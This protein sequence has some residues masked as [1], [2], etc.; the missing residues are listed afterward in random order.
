MVG[1]G[2]VRYGLV[3]YR[4]ESCWYDILNVVMLVRVWSGQVRSGIVLS[5]VGMIS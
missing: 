3:W 4:T 5:H 2:M 1:S